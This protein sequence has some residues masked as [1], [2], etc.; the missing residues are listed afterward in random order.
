MKQ[1]NDY[2]AADEARIEQ[3]YEV[4]VLLEEEAETYY[5]ENRIAETNGMWEPPT[6]W[7]DSTLDQMGEDLRIAKEEL[8]I[9]KRKYH[10]RYGEE[11]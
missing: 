10:I 1:I 4:V 8:T 7:T 11:Y 2:R 9:A 6:P 3:L 5:H